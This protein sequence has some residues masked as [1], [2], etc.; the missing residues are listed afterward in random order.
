MDKMDDGADEVDDV[1]DTGLDI[2]ILY[3]DHLK[4]LEKNIYPNE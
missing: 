3:S 2:V 1:V 4:F